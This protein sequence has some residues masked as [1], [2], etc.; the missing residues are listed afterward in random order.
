MT[1]NNEISFT[2]S[3]SE[4]QSAISNLND[5]ITQSLEKEYLEK[6]R[7][8]LKKIFLE[9]NSALEKG[10]SKEELNS[11]FEKAISTIGNLIAPGM[12]GLISDAVGLVKSVLTDLFSDKS[13]IEIERQKLIIENI[14]NELE[15]RNSIL[16]IA[17]LLNNSMLD[18]TKEQLEYQKESAKLLIQSLGIGNNIENLNENEV[19]SK[20]E[21]ILNRIQ[22]LKEQQ[23]ALT[24]D[25]ADDN[26]FEDIWEWVKS[27]W[28]GSKE[29]AIANIEAELSK[30]EME[31]E[32]YEEL[33]GLLKELNKLKKL[34]IEERY[35]EKE[36]IA[37]ISGDELAVFD[38]KIGYYR[39]L[40][41]RSEELKL[42]SLEQLE[43]E[44]KLQ[45][46]VADRTDFL[47]QQYDKE[48]ELVIKRA[49]LGG[50][51]EQEL[52][53]LRLQAI[54]NL[55]EAKKKE[56]ELFGSTL[57]REM[58]LVD[59]ELERLSL[60]QEINNELGT[61][62]ILYDENIRK[63]LRMIIEAKKL[64][65]I[66]AE[67]Q[68]IMTTAQ[69]LLEQGLSISEINNILGTKLTP[70]DLSEYNNITL[71]NIEEL[72]SNMSNLET[73]RNSST[74]LPTMMNAT[75]DI[76]INELDELQEHKQLLIKQNR[77]LESINNNIRGGKSS[78]T[79]NTPLTAGGWNRF[80]REM[81]RVNRS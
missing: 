34:E 2:L 18:S 37:S 33:I 27:F 3:K 73:L 49:K 38:A 22:Y 1:A 5:S 36:I 13:I 26:I 55:I 62:G 19:L 28:G 76:L 65:D 51:S 60:E 11:L 6:F 8:T 43:I 63:Q 71:P 81:E 17:L 61:Q 56:I 21:E 79:D 41:R 35:K 31:A 53:E 67:Q 58:E 4:L 32:Q 75:N 45:D 7:E 40:L 64:G 23:N 69:A 68:A 39:E 30:L 52:S 14:N 44:Q 78:Y 24:S 48:Q 74:L 50:A 46:I 47:I 9:L 16:E 57:D 66:Q 77:L 15:K 72:L 70:S 12:G 25:L 59:L 29:D 20:Y 10:L 80:V 54:E 42:S